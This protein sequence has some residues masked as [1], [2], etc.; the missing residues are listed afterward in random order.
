MSEEYKENNPLVVEF[1]G[2]L[3]NIDYKYQTIDTISYSTALNAFSTLYPELASGSL[4]PED[5]A[6]QLDEMAAKD[7]LYE[8]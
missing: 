1:V 5:M 2:L 6:K 4:T 3:D 7:A 8:K